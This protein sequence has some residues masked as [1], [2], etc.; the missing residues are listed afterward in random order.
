M[1]FELVTIIGVVRVAAPLALT[2]V[3]LFSCNRGVDDRIGRAY[4]L[5]RRPSESNKDR[6][7]ALLQDSDRDVRSTALVVMGTIDRDRAKL[8]AVAG[9]T[10][11]DG[12]VRATAVVLCAEGADEATVR[13]ITALATDDPVWQVR[14][15]ALEA[16]AASEDPA[17]REA[18][19]RALSD[20]V[21]YVRRAALRAGIAHPGLV[22]VDLVNALVAT[23]PDWEN[24]VAAST[25]LGAS[26]DPAAYAGLDAAALDPNEFVR[27]TASRERRAMERAGVPR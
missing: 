14:T 23:D 11:P 19:S 13:T 16:L 10:D 1:V 3:T 27:T 18:F 5:A 25:M 22:P 8:M 2:I 26:K 9:L 24:R 6:I 17:V 4:A 7:A 20:S 21:R 12:M 15:R